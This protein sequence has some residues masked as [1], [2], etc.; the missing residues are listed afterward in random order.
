MLPIFYSLFPTRCLLCR[1]ALATHQPLCQA[2]QEDLPWQ[3][4]VCLRCGLSLTDA[5][6]P[7]HSDSTKH[8]GQC[9][10]QPPPFE[11]TVAVWRYQAPLT[12]LITQLKFQ[13]QVSSGQLLGELISSKILE[14]YGDQPLPECMVPV[15]LHPRRV[16]TRGYNQAILLAKPIAKALRIPLNLRCL[17]RTQHTLPQSRLPGQARRRNLQHAF[18]MTQPFTHKHVAIVDDVVTTGQTVTAISHLLRQQGV[19]KIDIWCAARTQKRT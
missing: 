6:F 17:T 3:T 8:C 16:W 19:K 1:R 15:P 4:N 9:L 18:T 14:I 2:C 13:Q 12:S 11:R 7:R 5:L 10:Q